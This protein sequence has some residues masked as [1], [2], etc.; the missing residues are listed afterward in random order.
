[1]TQADEAVAI[2]HEDISQKVVARANFSDKKIVLPEDYDRYGHGTHVAGIVAAVHN[3]TGVAGV[4]PECTILDAKVLNDSGSGSSSVI[5]KGIDWAVANG[6]KVINMSLG[7]RVSSRTLETAVNNAWNQGVVIVAAAGNAGTPAQI[8]PG[9]YPKVIAVAATDNRDVKASFST[10]GK[11]VDV[12]APGVNVYSTFPNYLFALETQTAVLGVMTSPAAPPWHHPSSLPRL[13]LPG[14]H[15][16]APRTRRSGQTS[17][18]PPTQSMG[19]APT[20]H[21]A[22]STQTTPSGR[23]RPDRGPV[24]LPGG[25][26]HCHG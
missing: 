4:C 22:A 17:N 21:M 1:M 24:R 7:Q 23:Q 2:N 3:S 18:P 10:Y 11:W 19:Q 12:A 13:R 16:P 9:A 26:G 25:L 20:G 15:M 8:Y 5:A 6:A 14:V